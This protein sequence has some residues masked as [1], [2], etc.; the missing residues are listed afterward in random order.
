M[1]TYY[2][3]FLINKEQEYL[4]YNVHSVHANTEP[5][6]G[7]TVHTDPAEA[8]WQTQTLGFES[9]PAQYCTSELD[10]FPE[11]MDMCF[12]KSPPSCSEYL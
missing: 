9:A 3:H 7:L 4:Y 11:R 2:E 5:G 1:C 10:I 8:G 6:V 12:P